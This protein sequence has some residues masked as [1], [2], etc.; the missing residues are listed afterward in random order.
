MLCKNNKPKK[1]KTLENV[2]LKDVPT[3]LDENWSS[4]YY[5]TL[6]RKI[7]ICTIYV[8]FNKIN[9]YFYDVKFVFNFFSTNAI[10]LSKTY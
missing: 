9:K 6:V 8:S 7:Y 5:T 3:A 10:Y 1:M 2:V 4:N